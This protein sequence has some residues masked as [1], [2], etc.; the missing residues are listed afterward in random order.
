MT[1]LRYGTVAG[2]ASAALAL[3]RWW[4]GRP[5]YV[6]RRMSLAAPGHKMA[7]NL[8]KSTMRSPVGAVV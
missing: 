5:N 1:R 6:A 2:V 4:R 3:Y 8:E 7:P